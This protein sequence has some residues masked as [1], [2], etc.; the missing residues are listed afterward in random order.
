[1][2]IFENKKIIDDPLFNNQG[3]SKSILLATEAVTKHTVH[4]MIVWKGKLWLAMGFGVNGTGRCVIRSYD[5]NTDTLTDEYEVPVDNYTGAP[6]W[7]CLAIFNGNFYAGL[8]NHTDNDTSTGDIY[9]YDGS[10][11]SKIYDGGHRDIYSMEVY[12]GKL[13]ATTG[14]TGGGAGK[15]LVSSDG[16]AFT[17]LKTFS[18]D[19]VRSLCSWNG[20]LYIGLRQSARL[21][22]YDGSSFFDH[23]APPSSSGQVKSIIA[24]R[25]KLY[26]AGSSAIV[27]T[28]DPD[29]D[30]WTTEKDLTATET[31]MYHP[32]VYAGSL[33]YPTN[34]KTAGFHLWK[35]DGQAWTQDLSDETT[36]GIGHACRQ[37]AGY[38]WLGTGKN[39]AY[40]LYLWRKAEKESGGGLDVNKLITQYVD[41]GG[42]IKPAN[43]DTIAADRS[44]YVDLVD[45]FIA[46]STE[47]GEIG[48][49]GWVN[50]A[51]SVAKTAPVNN[52]PGIRNLSTGAVVNTIASIVLSITAGAGEIQPEEM[53]DITFII[54]PAQNTNQEIR[55]GITND[56]GVAPPTNA[57]YI[58]HDTGGTNP[59][60]WVGVTRKAS[61]STELVSTVTVSAATWYTLRMRRISSTEIEFFVN[62]TSI[63]TSTTNLMSGASQPFMQIENLT[64]TDIS[65]DIDYF[66]LKITGLSR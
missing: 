29:T 35:F 52:H 8:G 4:K 38:L 23:G 62:G 34:A 7:R 64:A 66:R 49:L 31:E 50:P 36:A 44:T 28:F 63:G 14:D 1:M 48:E 32:E 22:S 56:S 43:I 20:R 39:A 53:F 24:Y 45:E 12:N 51:G 41:D 59:T 37:Y 15:L 5:I 58:E 19:W 60:V 55:V 21:W 40:D 25:G 13:Y 54:N 3:W 10:T 17:T 57:I 16:A 46:G 27:Y 33:W 47:T 18:A 30:I 42:K 65:V 26:C 9:K 6:Y 61:V 2:S 11:W